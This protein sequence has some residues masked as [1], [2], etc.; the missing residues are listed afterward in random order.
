MDNREK[1]QGFDPSANFDALDE[2][3]REVVMEGLRCIAITEVGKELGID[4]SDDFE[5]QKHISAQATS[6]LEQT[7]DIDAVEDGLL[8]LELEMVEA[9]HPVWLQ[10]LEETREK[11]S[12]EN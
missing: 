10:I 6:S 4:L 11:Y 5:T 7:E 9:K 12:K 3:R 8:T 1:G 2:S